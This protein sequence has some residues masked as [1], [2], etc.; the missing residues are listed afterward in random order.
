MKVHVELLTP[1]R[2]IFLQY[3]I[4]IAGILSFFSYDITNLFVDQNDV[5]RWWEVRMIVVNSGYCLWILL[6]KLFPGNA[7]LNVIINIGLCIFI[8]DV[9]GRIIGDTHRNMW[10]WVALL[11]T[12]LICYYEYRKRQRGASPSKVSC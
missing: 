9:V 3:A 7:K 11:L 8:S 4:S 6:P 10:D 2:I 5:K 12:L 1:T